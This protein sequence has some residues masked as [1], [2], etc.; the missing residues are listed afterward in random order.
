VRIAIGTQCG[1]VQVWKYDCNG[2]LSNVFAVT[3]GET[4]PRKVAFIAKNDRIAVFG[5]SDG[6]VYVCFAC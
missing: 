4:V 6:Y 5:T 3:I 2:M 1:S